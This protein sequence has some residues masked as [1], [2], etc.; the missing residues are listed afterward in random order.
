MGATNL[1]L[2]LMSSF[3]NYFL[4]LWIDGS[5]SLFI[6]YNGSPPIMA[7]NVIIILK[8]LT[9]KQVIQT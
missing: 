2:E 7:Q 3:K 9:L 4:K 8:N 6:L 5:Q 1:E